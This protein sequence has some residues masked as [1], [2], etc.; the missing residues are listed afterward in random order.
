[1]RGH[2]C[3]QRRLAGQPRKHTYKQQMMELYGHGN[4]GLELGLELVRAGFLEE[5]MPG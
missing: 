4:E 1:M 3:L 5:V 2:P